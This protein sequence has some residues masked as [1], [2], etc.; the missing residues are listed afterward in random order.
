MGGTFGP[1]TYGVPVEAIA[2][3]VTDA[4]TAHNINSLIFMA[5]GFALARANPAGLANTRRKAKR[6]SMR[7]PS[8]REAWLAERQAER[9]VR[10]AEQRDDRVVRVKHVAVRV[11]TDRDRSRL[12]AV[13]EV[14]PRG[15]GRQRAGRVVGRR[16][17]RVIDGVH[18]T[19][20]RRA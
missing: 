9:C 17:A 13:A 20:H 18:R 14:R 16:R 10:S 15:F 8:P 12:G 4:R 3:C 11:V 19:S 7:S 5:F 6:A 1:C 2:P